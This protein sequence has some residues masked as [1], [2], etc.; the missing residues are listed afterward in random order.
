MKI[1]ELIDM[2]LEAQ[3]DTSRE[4]SISDDVE[5]NDGVGGTCKGHA[6][7]ITKAERFSG[8]VYIVFHDWR[9]DKENKE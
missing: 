1:K 2:I 4:I 7:D 3:P 8:D 5:F 9:E 6:F